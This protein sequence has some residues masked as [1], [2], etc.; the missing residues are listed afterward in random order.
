MAEI[1][2][3]SVWDSS[4]G[5]SA[6]LWSPLSFKRENYICIQKISFE[7]LGQYF[8]V[9]KFP[10]CEIHQECVLTVSNFK[11]KKKK[12]GKDGS[13][14]KNTGCSSR[15]PGCASQSTHSVSQTSVLQF[16]GIRWPLLTFLGTRDSHSHVTHTHTRRNTHTYKL[17]LFK[18]LKIFKNAVHNIKTGHLQALFIQ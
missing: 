3:R 2:P 5:T 8:L 14:I 13:R 11:K 6:I 18:Q 12:V 10:K 15:K 16:Q 17:N 9:C 4:L 1:L 7:V